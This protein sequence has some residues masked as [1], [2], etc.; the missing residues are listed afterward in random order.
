MTS[1]EF[2]EFMQGIVI[3]VKDMP[4]KKQW[5]KIT[6]K[7]SEVKDADSGYIDIGEITKQ[8]EK[9]VKDWSK[10]FPGQPPD[11]YF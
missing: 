10:K 7:L 1:R 3:G 5:K 2:I 6:E 8:W 4:T 9:K 11:I